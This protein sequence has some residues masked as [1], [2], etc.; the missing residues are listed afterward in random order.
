MTVSAATVK[1]LRVKTGIGIMECKTALQEAGGDIEKAMDLLRKKGVTKAA[2]KAGRPT[3]QGSIGSYIHHGGRVG[4]L[5][6]VRC[7]TD[8]VAR[9]EDFQELVK[10]LAM[11]VTAA[12]PWYV[13]REDVP[14]E[15]LQKE[16]DIYTEQARESGKPEKIIEKIVDGK[17]DK[18]F[19]EVCLLE[20]PF[21]KDDEKS[22]REVLN[23][24][25]ALLGENMVVRRFQRFQLGEE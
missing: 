21:I 6:E 15:V 18:F 3:G 7:E 16:K 20:Q 8:F 12:N 13:S 24:K 19:Q 23:E 11:H 17:L 4:V 2:K 25:I 14:P 22:V 1:E 10:D 5:I 9:T